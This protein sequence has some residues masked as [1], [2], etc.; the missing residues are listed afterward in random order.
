MLN[1]VR[2]HGQAPFTL[3]AVH[4]GPGGVGEARPF[5]E[6]LSKEFGVVEPYLLSESLEGQIDD[7]RTAI[8]RYAD[9]PVTLIGHSYGAM[10][11]YMFAARF[12]ELVEKLIMISSGLLEKNGVAR[13]NKLRMSRLSDAG[14]KE[15]RKARD[16]Y[17]S[18]IGKAKNL[19]FAN[20]F[21]LVQQADAYDPLPHPNDLE[22]VRP[23][24]YESVWKDV[25]S[26]RDSGELAAYGR[27]IKCPVLVIHGAYDPRSASAIQHSLDKHVKDFRFILLQK[28]GHY[29]WYEKQARATFY[30]EI[31]KNLV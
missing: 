30:A 13:I 3:V 27:G 17:Q 12:P 5:A 29:P 14:K 1:N 25:L 31:V 7:L 15:L 24:L 23:A 16:E 20:L 11:C 28:C 22:V 10:L 21:T 8:G 9:A 4:G 6:E 2:L 19:A 26:L 18:A